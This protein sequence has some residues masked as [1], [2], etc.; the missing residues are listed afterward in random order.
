MQMPSK[1]AERLQRIEQWRQHGHD[2]IDHGLGHC[3]FLCLESVQLRRLQK[4]EAIGRRHRDIEGDAL[5]MH[6][7]RHV[8][9]GGAEPPHF[10]VE[11]RLA[12]DLLAVHSEDDVAVLSSAR[13]AGPLA[14]IPITT[15]RLSISV[16]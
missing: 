13:A 16:E 9:A 5:M 1:E 2:V 15:T 10:L 11:G 14:E 3:R 8:D 12:C 4:L 6:S 7:E